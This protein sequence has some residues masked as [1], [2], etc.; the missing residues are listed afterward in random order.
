MWH[1]GSA[2]VRSR[3]YVL[4]LHVLHKCTKSAW[5]LLGHT[6]ENSH[7][8]ADFSRIKSWVEECS[9]SHSRCRQSDK[10]L[11]TRVID[12]SGA[13]VT[14]QLVVT[15]GKH[16][17]YAALS[18]CW[19]RSQ[20]VVTTSETIAS[21]LEGISC[22]ALPKT[23]QDAVIT[24]KSLGFTYLWVDAL[25]IQ[26]DN[27][28][29]KEREMALMQQI[30]QNASITIVAARASDSTQGFLNINWGLAPT[31][32]LP[33]IQYLEPSKSENRI[34]SIGL[35]L[36][37]I[38]RVREPLHTRAWTLQEVL[39]APRLLVYGRNRLVWKCLQG[40]HVDD[41][42]DWNGYCAIAGLTTIRFGR[43]GEIIRPP[44]STQSA[45][46]VAYTSEPERQPE[47]F[48]IWKRVIMDYSSRHLTNPMDKLPALSG[49]ATYFRD[50]MEDTYLAGLWEKQLVYQL[51]WIPK[52]KAT[53]Q[54]VWRAPS[55]SWVSVDGSIVF[56]ADKFLHCDKMAELRSCKVTPAMQTAPLSRVISGSL[57]LHGHLK[58]NV[59]DF[60]GRL[61]FARPADETDGLFGKIILDADEE[62]P[63]GEMDEAEEIEE[64][65]ELSMS[66]RSNIESRRSSHLGIY[67]CLMF[68]RCFKQASSYG[69][70][71][72]IEYV[73]G[74]ALSRTRGGTFRRVG[75]FI[76]NAECTHWFQKSE[77]RTIVIK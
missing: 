22:S 57:C 11:P 30:F 52:D 6:L 32:V 74:F 26:Q 20:A 1:S 44:L 13:P 40:E 68:L 2:K 75:Y 67:W 72:V 64:I 15:S 16:S 50:A 65:D 9:E 14:V 46:I 53:R 23:L 25:C 33:I 29:D 61:P 8:G 24:A 5:N 4:L 43:R 41:E 31:T 62:N 18:Y 60:G 19:G 34:G 59:R 7:L 17:P 63:D 70:Y 10:P 58:A 12:I 42:T 47:L 71:E 55:W 36:E 39:L 77:K 66:A 38:D 54:G 27:I 45:D 69:S 49:I 21:H 28:E 51:S 35:Y 48:R 73:W 37:E 76:G 3:E 56:Y